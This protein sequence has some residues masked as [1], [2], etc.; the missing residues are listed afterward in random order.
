MRAVLLLFSLTLSLCGCSQPESD[1][2][3]SIKEIDVTT[4]A[5]ASTVSNPEIEAAIRNV[6]DLRDHNMR[7]TSVDIRGDFA[8]VTA[9]SNS[10]NLDP[11]TLLLGR[12]DG[13]RVLDF[14][15]ALEGVGEQFGVPADTIKEWGL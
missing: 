10:A 2:T 4:P 7:L 5:P 9:E 14:G 6:A 3:G 15:T 1:D 8:L 12:K 11:L 13:W